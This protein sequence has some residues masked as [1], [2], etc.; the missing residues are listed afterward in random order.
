MIEVL[1]AAVLIVV[2]ACAAAAIGDAHAQRR[3]EDQAARR[4]SRHRHPSYVK[5]IRR[6]YDWSEDD[7]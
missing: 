4:G 5:R 7:R 2:L 6:P 3:L 1:A